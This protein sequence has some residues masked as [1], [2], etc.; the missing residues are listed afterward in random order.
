MPVALAGK[1]ATSNAGF[2]YD[3]NVPVQG[4]KT[5]VA[6]AFSQYARC[7]GDFKCYG[8]A[9]NAKAAAMGFKPN[10]SPCRSRTCTMGYTMLATVGWKT[11]ATDNVLTE[12]KKR[13]FRYTEWVAF[14][15]PEFPMAPDFSNPPKYG[16]LYD[17]DVDD[18]ENINLYNECKKD[19][20]SSACGVH[21][22]ILEALAAHLHACGNKG[23]PVEVPK[24]EYLPQMCALPS[25]KQTTTIQTT[26]AATTLVT[27][28]DTPTVPSHEGGSSSTTV[29]TT[30]ITSKIPSG[31]NG[32]GGKGA[33]TTTATMA[34]ADSDST[35]TPAPGGDGGKTTLDPSP[36]GMTTLPSSTVPSSMPSESPKKSNIP[37]IAGAGGGGFV[38][39]VLLAFICRKWCCSSGE[40]NGY[41]IQANPTPSTFNVAFDFDSDEDL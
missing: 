6:S 14:N 33:T 40:A 27:V 16:E 28:T 31:G 24:V 39:L 12:L 5:V 17:H 19:S 3:T 10:I 32:N 30:V 23:C 9:G 26:S 21:I 18:M 36:G 25:A 22:S 20:T 7:S 13:T 34:T 38:V 29:S 11:V 8:A 35:A 15:T 37:L 1:D 2:P 41:S 4:K